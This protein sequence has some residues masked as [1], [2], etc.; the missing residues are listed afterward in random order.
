MQKNVWEK[1]YQ[2]PRLVTGSKEPQTSVKDFLRWLRREQNLPLENI[3]AIDL[4][5]GNGKN[6][7]Y[8][9][10]LDFGNNVVGIDISETALTHARFHAH[11]L[12]EKE[13]IDATQVT[14]ENRNIGE[15]L[16]Y[17]DNSFDLALDVTS[18]NSLSEKERTIYMKEIHRILKPGGYFFV[19]A[20]CKDGDK[21][22]A[23]LLASNQGGEKDTYILPELGLAERVFSR[24]DFIATY[25]NPD[26]P[27]FEILELEKETHY[28]KFAGRSYK[29]NFWVAYLRKTA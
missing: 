20:L 18:S 4:G 12:V 15:T 10:E 6:S 5:C 29:R 21:N 22:A 13:K 17:A 16:P 19:R 1:E 9:A 14:Y 23:A 11:E 27:L 26:F 7:N 25:A 8:I 3:R 2:N 24:A 28:T